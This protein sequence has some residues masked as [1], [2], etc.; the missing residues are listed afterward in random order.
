MDIMEIL[1][2]IATSITLLLIGIFVLTIP[3]MP[4][5]MTAIMEMLLVIVMLFLWSM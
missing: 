1:F 3:G 4:I 2:K 5:L